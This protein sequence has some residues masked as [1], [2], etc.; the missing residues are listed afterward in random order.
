MN[1]DKYRDWLSKFMNEPPTLVKTRDFNGN[2][3]M[4]DRAKLLNLSIEQAF[5]IQ[6]DPL[7][8]KHL[9]TIIP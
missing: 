4:S 3:G 5:R 7:L 1:L 8:A 9:V 2:E 6:Q